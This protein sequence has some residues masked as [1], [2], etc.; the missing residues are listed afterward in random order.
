MNAAPRRTTPLD[1]AQYN[2]DSR[3]AASATDLKARARGGD[4]PAA[5]RDGSAGP[6]QPTNIRAVRIEPNARSNAQ[7][8]PASAQEL[9]RDQHRLQLQSIARAKRLVLN[10]LARG[11][12]L[13]L[14]VSAPVLL[15]WI[16]VH[17]LGNS[18]GEVS[19]TELSQLTLLAITVA[20]FGSLAHRVRDDRRFATLAAGFFACML[21][22]ECD[23]WLDLLVDGLWQGLVAFVAIACLTYSLMDWRSTL[24]GMAR[25]VNSR[26]G[27]VLLVAVVL[28]LVYS[29]LFGMSG[30][31][32]DLLGDG[33]VRLF[34][35]AVEESTELLAYFLV[36]GASVSY[37]MSR[38]RRLQKP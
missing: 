30:L 13:A 1:N 14:L 10:A 34:K 38:F 22:R 3:D 20:T 32:R 8:E 2:P 29:R 27:S 4:M 17:G 26:A 11:A 12:L 28:L 7:I 31:W 35:N 5:K 18:I 33:Y 23:A 37:A 24:R 15:L 16:D 25:L 21:L 9:A 36:V 19:A 6:R